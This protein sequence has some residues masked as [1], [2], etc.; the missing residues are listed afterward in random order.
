MI[1]VLSTDLD[2]LKKNLNRSISRACKTSN[3]CVVFVDCFLLYRMYNLRR[4]E[5]F[6]T[7]DKLAIRVKGNATIIRH[8]P[9]FIGYSQIF[10]PE[11]SLPVSVKPARQE[12]S[13]V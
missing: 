9:P 13:P 10:L 3:L 11:R 2:V 4:N 5:V 1:T 8:F 12:H 6:F 7:I